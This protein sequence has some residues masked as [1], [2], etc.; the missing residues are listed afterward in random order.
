[1]NESLSDQFTKTDDEAGLLKPVISDLLR[2][3]PDAWAEFNPDSL[4]VLQ[5]STLLLL[6]AAG[7]VERRGWVRCDMVGHPT[8]LE[9]RLQ[10]TGEDGLAKAMEFS[11]EAM[12]DVWGESYRAW[13]E[14]AQGTISPF[15]AESRNPNEW[16]LTADGVLARGDLNGKNPERVYDFVL[17]R[18]F[19]GPG[20]GFRIMANTFPPQETRKN[21]T[22]VTLEE[23][24]AS[25][26]RPPV[27]GEGRLLEFRKIEKP[28]GPQSVNLTNWKEGA[29]EF[30][31]SF[32]KMLDTKFE[33]L[34]KKS[35]EASVPSAGKK[36]K[37]QEP[38]APTYLFSHEGAF[39]RIRFDG[40]FGTIRTDLK[41]SKYIF[42]MLQQPNKI[43]LA[44]ELHTLVAGMDRVTTLEEE[45]SEVQPAEKVHCGADEGELRDLQRQLSRTKADLERAQEE[46]D[47]VEVSHCQEEIEALLKRIREMTSLGGKLRGTDLS[48]R[49]GKSVAKAINLVI[50]KCK[51]EYHLPKLAAHLDTSLDRGRTCSYRPALPM[52]DWKF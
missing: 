8:S 51:R 44:N 52:P 12:Y 26:P 29:D 19:Y 32:S 31:N 42:T 24:L 10:A 40:E 33:T 16:R 41:G 9:A 23:N 5:S 20:H 49:L 50:S 1:V 36:V 34:W 43:F 45:P 22:E 11:S 37:D 30:T 35:Q 28:A 21:P 6:V 14:K 46:N 48:E 27:L 4:T 17:K 25:R 47:N 18:G 38:A 39:F 13:R 3:I 2:T 15:H 7:F